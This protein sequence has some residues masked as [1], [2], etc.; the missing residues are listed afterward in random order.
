MTQITLENTD[1]TLPRK[2]GR[3]LLRHAA[4]VIETNESDI[5]ETSDGSQV[6]K[7]IQ[8]TL[9]EYDKE[10]VFT[11]DIIDR[12]CRLEGTKWADFN[13]HGKP[14]TSYQLHKLLRPYGIK[15]EPEPVRIEGER[16]RGFKTANLLI[17]SPCLSPERRDV[18]DIRDKVDKVDPVEG[19]GDTVELSREEEELVRGI[20][21]P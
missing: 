1:V 2:Q 13:W 6:I 9:I 3:Q 16:L 21:W 17:A 4:S 15:P 8:T 20:Q 12:L 5:V 7:D 10:Y 19:L 18:C 11:R 14:I